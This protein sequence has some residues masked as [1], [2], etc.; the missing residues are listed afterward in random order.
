[1]KKIKETIILLLIFVACS[2]ST[3]GLHIYEKD[4]RWVLHWPKISYYHINN[5]D[6]ELLNLLF[7]PPKL[8][9]DYHWINIDTMQ[10]SDPVFADS[11]FWVETVER[12]AFGY[13]G[14]I[15]ITVAHRLTQYTES[16]VWLDNDN[17][18]PYVKTFYIVTEEFPLSFTVVGDHQ[19]SI[20]Y[21]MEYDKSLEPT[22]DFS[23]TLTGCSINIRDGKYFSDILFFADE[24]LDENKIEEILNPILLN[25]EHGPVE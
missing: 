13:Y 9:K 8:S 10:Y 7:D 18:P 16:P 4:I 15:Q 1:M 21:Y 12:K 23:E 25:L 11:E 6:S 19:V 24:I 3:C 20:C 2:L 5:Q 17:I 22:N 14:D